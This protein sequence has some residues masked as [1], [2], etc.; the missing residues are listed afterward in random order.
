MPVKYH[1]F[2]LPSKVRVDEGV[3]QSGTFLRC[4]AEPFERGFGHTLG[5]MLRRVML[6]CLEAPA[7]IS[8]RIEGVPHE[9]MA[10]E[11]IVEDMIHIVLNFKGVLLRRLPLEENQ[12]SRSPLMLSRTLEITQ[13]MLDQHGGQFVVSAQHLIGECEF[14]VVNPEH[15]LFNT[16]QPMQK[17]F[18]LKVGYG[19]GY[20]PSER[21]TIA[22]K[23]EGEIAIDAA[24][25]PVRLVNYFVEKTRVGQDT[26]YDR[27]VLEI[28]TDGRVRPEEALT[29]S[30]QI[31]SLHLS[32]FDEMKLHE[33]AFEQEE[34]ELSA[35]CGRL[36]SKLSL[37]ISEVELSVRSA[38]CLSHAGVETVGDLV[39][40]PEAEMLKFRNFG[41]KSLNEIK[42][43]L[44][45]MELHLE[46]DLSKFG[47]HSGNI[48]QVIGDYL[49]SQ[50][51]QEE[52]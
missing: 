6:T 14:E 31:A 19:R 7:F 16:T 23:L 21:Q 12:D 34:E 26:D 22:N 28:T 51:K 3:G 43:K 29:F 33:L 13:E 24:Y 39:L 30:A 41:K 49:Q 46:M 32:I 44:G 1:K 27:L 47:I 36:L 38:N 18:D 52:S 25:S 8:I 42:S 35:D 37:P 50:N 48:E 40:M 10:V 2:E 9:Y 4:T 15:V 20:V 17:R 5:N 11:G 45:D